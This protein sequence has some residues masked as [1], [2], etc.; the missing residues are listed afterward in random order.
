MQF[1]PIPAHQPLKQQLI[2]VAQ[3]NQVPHAQLFWGSEGSSQLSLALAFATYLNC[4]HRLADDACGQCPSCRKMHKLI[5]PDVKFVFP[6][7]ATKHIAGKDVVSN[8][9]L[10][11]W[12][13][14]VHAHPYGSIGDWSG[15]IG[16]EHKQ[17]AIPREEARHIAQ[18]VSFKA[19]EGTYKVVLVWLPE[20]LH[21]AAANA[22]L[23]VLEEPPPHTIFLLA[24][25]APEKIMNTIR[26]RTQAIYV[27]AFTDEA[28]TQLLTEH[29]TLAPEQIASVVTLADGNVN[30][31]FKLAVDVQGDDLERF[32][33]WMRAC[34]AQNLSQLVAQAEAFQQ[35]PREGQRNFLAYALHMLREVLIM[36]VGQ[37]SLARTTKTEQAFNQKLGQTLT[38]PQL[39]CYVTWINQ[40]CNQLTRNA[41]AKL[42]WLDLSLRISRAFI[43][44]R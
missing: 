16:S 12:R 27:P 30:K 15:Y 26:S 3:G 29:H 41:N 14:F 36:H 1:V 43:N 35:L 42:L 5:H 38:Y 4:Q 13:S 11:P 32:A 9:F 22:L 37:T 34:Y 44:A 25:I 24:S 20:Y 21:P 8:S 40:A 17:L 18:H 31:A 6:T 2:H 33:T 39:K 28:I 7:S 10:G 23:S 19:L